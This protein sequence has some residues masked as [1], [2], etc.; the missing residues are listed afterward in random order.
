MCQSCVD[1]LFSSGPAPCPIHGCHRTLRKARFREQ[2]FEDLQ[3]EREVD[4]RRRIAD[5]FVLTQENFETLEDYNDYL[6]QME[7]LTF[8][9]LHKIDVPATEAKIKAYAAQNT[10]DDSDQRNLL[11][12]M[13]GA[14][15]VDSGTV[16]SDAQSKIQLKRSS[17]RNEKIKVK[18][19]DTQFD[20]DVSEYRLK[21]L[22]KILAPVKEKAYSPFA[23][24]RPQH[25]HYVLQDHYDHPW[26]EQ[27]RTDP[28]ILAGGYTVQEYYQRTLFE[29][30]SGLEVFVE[31]EVADRP[32]GIQM[33]G[34]SLTEASKSKSIPMDDSD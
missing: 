13:P 7:T 22:R 32:L 31:D 19:S 30:F 34:L 3:I 4:I 23:G 5:A 8:N 29:A 28:Q 9:L 10:K 15:S 17:A 20:S 18:G 26:L 25:E 6:E 1:R 24:F 12:K 27:A 33:Q 16:R 21:G 2:R 14:D 11:D